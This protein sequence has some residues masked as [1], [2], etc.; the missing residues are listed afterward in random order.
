[1]SQAIAFASGVSE[2]DA[3]GCTCRC[4]AGSNL[5]MTHSQWRNLD[6]ASLPLWRWLALDTLDLGGYAQVS[7]KTG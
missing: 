5:S 3:T 6:G 1:M 2:H 7:F 4:G